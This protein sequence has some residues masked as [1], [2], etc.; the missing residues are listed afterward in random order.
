MVIMVFLKFDNSANMG[1]DSS[2]QGNNWTTSGTIIQNKD[3]PSNSFATLNPSLDV[4]NGMILS[5]ARFDAKGWDSG[6][7]RFAGA[8][9]WCIKW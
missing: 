8:N 1:L 2:G 6:N 5:N 3:T 7:H 9:P 4:N